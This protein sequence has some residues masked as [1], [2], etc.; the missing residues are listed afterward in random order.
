M[1]FALMVKDFACFFVYWDE[2]DFIFLKRKKLWGP[3]KKKKVAK[4][5]YLRFAVRLEM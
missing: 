3:R 4:V 1:L 5:P 2:I